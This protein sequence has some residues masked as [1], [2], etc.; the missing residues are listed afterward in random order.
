M[1]SHFLPEQK[2]LY[3]K[4]SGF[5][6][7]VIEKCRTIAL[8]GWQ[9]EFRSIK[10]EKSYKGSVLHIAVFINELR[11]DDDLN[12]VFSATFSSHLF[13]KSFDSFSFINA[14]LALKDREDGDS[15]TLLS[16]QTTYRSY[17]HSIEKSAFFP[18]QIQGNLAE[19]ILLDVLE[20]SIKEMQLVSNKEEEF[21]KKKK[22][23]L[24][25]F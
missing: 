7:Q 21:L 19:F 11:M 18:V 23:N 2:A 22:R 9:L 15:R 24:K 14:H 4:I 20:R 5:Y 1:K 17:A 10:D 3:K 13:H 12:A 8:N 16:V 25:I 6:F